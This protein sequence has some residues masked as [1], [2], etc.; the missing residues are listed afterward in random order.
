MYFYALGLCFTFCFLVKKDGSIVT[1]WW[2]NA[3]S[4]PGEVARQIF[5]DGIM[6]VA[7]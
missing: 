6:V 1:T 5:K 3:Q 2:G 4:W 7:T